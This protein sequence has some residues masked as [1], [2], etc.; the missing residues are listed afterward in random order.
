MSSEIFLVSD[1]QQIIQECK[2]R[3]PEVK[4]AAEKALALLKDQ[5]GGKRDWS[6]AGPHAED[7]ISPVSLG[8][9]SKNPKLVAIC[10]SSMQ[11]LIA[12]H[13][14]SE[15]QIPSFIQDLGSVINQGVDIQLKI[16]QAVLVILTGPV[17]GTLLGDAFRLVFELRDSRIPVV[18][19][20]AAASLRQGVMVTFDK[21]V[22][23]DETLKNGTCST[24]PTS[25]PLPDGTVK[26]L[27]PSAFDG[28][29]LF[30]D[31][32]VLT[33]STPP[34]GKQQLLMLN[35]LPRPF[36]LELIESILS[37]YA[38]VFRKHSELLLLLHQHLCPVLL[39][40]LSLTSAA[41]TSSFPLTLRL[42]RVVFLLLRLFSNE[43]V[44]ESERFLGLLIKIVAGEQ[45]SLEELESTPEEERKH[46]AHPGKE[47]P[48][49]FR[50]LAMECLRGLC[51]DAQLLRKV[52]N[53]GSSELPPSSSSSPP[54]TV[55][56]TQPHRHQQ[57]TTN[58]FSTLLST[59]NRIATEKPALLGVSSQMGGLGISHV[60]QGSVSPQGEVGGASGTNPY[61]S[62]EMVAGMVASGVSTVV[63]SLT[64]DSTAGLGPTSTVKVQ[65]IDQLDKLEPPPLPET[66]LYL[67]SL[68]CF[69]IVVE[70]FA[71]SVT[72]VYS[73]IVP[74]RSSLEV[75]KRKGGLVEQIQNAGDADTTRDMVEAGWPAI[76]AALSF[77]I[78]RNLSDELFVD[79]LS[80]LHEFTI[81]CGLLSLP[82]ERNAFISTL[83][84]FAVPQAVVS[85][86]AS[87]D[88][89]STPRSPSVMSS[90]EALGFTA[91]TGGAT[92]HQPPSLSSRNL[93]CLKVLISVTELLG[94][95]LGKSWFDI[96]EALQSSSFVLTPRRSTNSNGQR[97]QLNVPASP[98]PRRS[99]FSP[100]TPAPSSTSSR[101]DAPPAPS[102]ALVSEQDI[103]AVHASINHVFEVC[104]AELDD[105]AFTDFVEA[106]VRLSGEMM[107]L[108]GSTTEVVAGG[109]NAGGGSEVGS[110]HGS[111]T[112]LSSIPES[113]G[114][115]RRRASGMHTLKTNR[116]HGDRSFAIAKL[117]QISQINLR[118]LVS[119][120]PSLGWSTI[121][122]HLLL[123]L[124]HSISSSTNRL[125]AASTLD[126][127]LTS[128]IRSASSHPPEISARTQHLVLSSLARQ[129]EPLSS[130]TYFQQ[131]DV[132]IRK[133]GLEALYQ[134]LQ[135]AGHEMA[136]GWERV[137]A[138]LSSVCR[139]AGETGTLAEGSGGEVGL[140]VS[141]GGNVRVRPSASA[142]GGLGGGS[143]GNA[144]LV[145]TAFQSIT[146][147]I[148]D[149]LLSL[150][151]PDLKSCITA[152]A[153][154]S[155]QTDEVNISLSSIGSLW[156]VSDALQSRRSQKG[157]DGQAYDDLWLFIVREL[158][159]CCLDPRADVR[160]SA[161]QTLFRSIELY[162]STLD[163]KLWTECVWEII[164]P[165]FDSLK[166]FSMGV[167]EGVGAGGLSVGV[168]EEGEEGKWYESDC[169]A[170]SSV[171]G[172]F[173]SFFLTNLVNLPDAT[174]IW[175]RFLSQIGVAFA[176][177]IPS[178]STAAVQALSM[179]IVSWENSSTSSS[180]SS[181]KILE[182]LMKESWSTWESM[183]QDVL[184]VAEA[185]GSAT[186]PSSSS[187]PPSTPPFTQATL[188][189]FVNTSQPL[190]RQSTSLWSM[191]RL[192]SILSVLKG[193][194]TVPPGDDIRPDVD[195]L[196]PLQQAI[197]DVFAIL[198][199][200]SVPGS[201]A[202]FLQDLSSLITLAY[203]SSFAGEVVAEEKGRK[204]RRLTFVAVSKRAM[205][206]AVEVF[207]KHQGEVDLF[208]GGTVEQIVKA[209][210]LP[211]KLK[212][213]CPPSFRY[214]D[215]PPLWK[216]ATNHF[217]RIIKPICSVLSAHDS[218]LSPE[219]YQAI[220]S[221]LLDLY[222]GALLADCG[223]ADILS[224]EAQALDET[225]D[226]RYLSSLETDLIPIIGSSRVPDHL[227]VKLARCLQQASRFYRFETEGLKGAST[228]LGDEDGG[229]SKTTEQTLYGTTAEIIG[230][231]RERFRRWCFDVLFLLTQRVESNTESR[232][233]VATLCLP[234]LM[235]RC[236]LVLASYLADQPLRGAMPF[237][238][239]REEE[240]VY[241]LKKLLELTLFEKTF[242][243]RSPPNSNSSSQTEVPFRKHI[244]S[245][246][247]AHLF[248]LYPSLLALALLCRR[249][250]SAD[251]DGYLPIGSGYDGEEEIIGGKLDSRLMAGEALGLVGGCW[252]E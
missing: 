56:S 103:D 98:N 174:K 113:P 193:S 57:P 30:E 9:K 47:S 51:S 246:P 110:N 109:G 102:Q 211:I 131:I 145:R 168:E 46:H 64:M 226:L 194:M 108:G 34:T 248:H 39:R 189:A 5:S 106:L 17:N 130:S 227:I 93:A 18:S 49:W 101:S 155:R 94:G 8:M 7:L 65:C 36:G 233:R 91:L 220:W 126:E 238:R 217:L 139:K 31:L 24:S 232:K 252:E 207:L 190:L 167:G 107:G 50:V 223:A 195:T 86:L 178:I 244:L 149:F 231:P 202:V 136:T 11:R 152:L 60:E 237:P 84:R 85:A 250:A 21:I 78:G 200:S 162:G 125:Q 76:L 163:D 180:S 43:L 40:N 95:S 184:K 6:A 53:C 23:E 224:L 70:G 81:I 170:L 179:V 177:G 196:T 214:G 218:K 45:G 164:F 44:A 249:T 201:A 141:A 154:F 32:C 247:L 160:M 26:I 235:E 27:Y 120:D 15:A 77:F 132:D 245:S 25:T 146:L 2:R 156:N 66:Y 165:L 150:S 35:H 104:V 138:C 12:L 240:L 182:E 74:L 105:E 14:A 199:L 3:H 133:L 159:T 222:S 221:Q 169:L 123:A 37:N 203:A 204:P 192:Q 92:P 75:A 48:V 122:D 251:D 151:I 134:I 198:D 79:T 97:K 115:M 54:T 1:L 197:F 219:S 153:D 16:L 210:S 68:Q 127:L 58:I 73:S 41:A 80:S 205:E 111:S 188:L 20:T 183:G 137:F 121:V 171:G 22:A 173:S 234:A 216:T 206:V 243:A 236:S 228:E 28:Y 69:N 42:I 209:Y 59:L 119:N 187:P 148:T 112:D 166:A 176:S 100:P 191:A 87:S 89:P 117:A 96:L 29:R 118:R 114:P 225:F 19:S 90:V 172:I 99:S 82:T 157:P 215:E 129:V 212:Y 52:W 140:G 4:E 239:I 128:S 63:A 181:P 229:W 186:P 61:G 185:H 38:G 135:S 83:S 208:S 161:M 147:I 33:T 71:S 72:P 142:Q 175:K 116:Q 88:L 230:L 67:L 213:E 241:V 62:L 242:P 55:T 124:S 13:T 143:R 10:I 158:L 144:S